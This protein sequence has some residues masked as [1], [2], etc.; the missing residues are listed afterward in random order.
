LLK[1]AAASLGLGVLG[2]R[3]RAA[4]GLGIESLSG[5]LSLITGT[6]GN[7]L[8]LATDDGLVLV[9]SGAGR[10]GAA[11]LDTLTELTD[12]P[13][14]ALFNTHWH[15]DQ[16]GSN[17]VL[18]ARGAPI[19]AH[20]KTEQRLRAG[21]YVPAEDR[22][23]PAL[24]PPGVPTQTFY[25]HGATEIGGASIE[26]GYLIEAHTDGDIYVAFRDQNIIAV[27]GVLAPDRDPE[28]DWYGGGWLGGRLDSIELLLAASDAATRFVPSQGPVVDRT[29]VEAERDMMQT[30]FDRIV[31]HIRKGETVRDMLE[32]GVLDGLGREFADPYGLLYD[33]QK[34]FWANHDKLM[35]D[36]V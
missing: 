20:V 25:E 8:A 6:G 32:L 10:D 1:G 21:Y 16:V 7:Q 11:L 17:E 26:Y 22:Y 28:F 36:I 23:E 33:L 34:G 18:G 4:G 19:Y 12:A 30:L 5:R 29:D 14:A 13:V 15:P 2:S 31:E 24:A 35:H 9:D 27:G 3:P